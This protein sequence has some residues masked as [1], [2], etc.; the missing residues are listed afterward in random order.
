M[1]ITDMQ[2][3]TDICVKCVKKKKNKKQKR[4][5]TKLYPSLWIFFWEIGKYLDNFWKMR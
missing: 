1:K 2:I 4:Q 3:N 5:K